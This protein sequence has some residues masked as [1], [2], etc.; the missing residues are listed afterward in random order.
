MRKLQVELADFQHQLPR[1]TGRGKSMR[2][3]GRRKIK[4]AG[5]QQL[6]LDRRY[7]RKRIQD[8]KNQLA[9]VEKTQGTAQLSPPAPGV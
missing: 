5:E 8:I 4:S 2:P 3:L 6:E 7:L 9:K 1:L